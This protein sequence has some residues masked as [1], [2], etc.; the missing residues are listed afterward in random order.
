MGGAD[1]VSLVVSLWIQ[2]KEYKNRRSK[3]DE[4]VYFD[5][6]FVGFSY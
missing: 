2:I 6:H 3:N 1:S 5:R 4:K